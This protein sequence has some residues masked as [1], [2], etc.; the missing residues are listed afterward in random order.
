MRIA[1][2]SDYSLR[3][4]EALGVRTEPSTQRKLKPDFEGKGRL[5]DRQVYLNINSHF[6]RWKMSNV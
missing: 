5:N 1:L 2:L 3:D 6:F 4:T